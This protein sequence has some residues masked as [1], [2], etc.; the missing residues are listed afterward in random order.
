MSIP[1]A[2]TLIDVYRQ[3][4]PVDTDSETGYP[5]SVPQTKMATGVRAHI[6]AP[7]GSRVFG[8]GGEKERVMFSL[9]CDLCGVRG[10]DVIQDGNGE[11]YLV[12]WARDRSGLGIQ[13]TEGGLYQ[14]IGDV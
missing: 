5:A 3:V 1:I 9:R 7:S 10:D 12:A 4:T 2:T 6:G 8:P 13:F 11:Q 14:Q